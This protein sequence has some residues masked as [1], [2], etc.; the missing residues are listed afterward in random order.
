MREKT[1]VL[2]GVSLELGGL[3]AHGT[4]SDQKSL[5]A[6]GTD[7]G[8]GF[9]L[10]DDLLDVYADKKK[11]GKQVGGDIIANKKTFL[12][13]K[14]LEKARGKHKPE[15]EKWLASKKFDPRKKVKAITSIY[16]ELNIRELTEKK[17]N[18]FF[19]KGFVSLGQLSENKKM[20]PLVEFTKNLIHREF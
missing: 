9:Q 4:E 18:Y 13:I 20:N 1:A 19:D 7:I 5:R 8:I 17:M 15:L 3:V 2:V 11:F 16:N 10:K 6:F 12:L 14:A